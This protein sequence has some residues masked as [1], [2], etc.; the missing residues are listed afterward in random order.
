MKKLIIIL[1]LFCCESVKAQLKHYISIN[2]VFYANFFNGQN[3]K[4]DHVFLFPP[5]SYK[6]EKQK[7]GLELCYSQ[8]DV[9]YKGSNTAVKND[10][11]YIYERNLALNVHYGILQHRR[12]AINP[13]AGV[14]FRFYDA[15]VFDGWSRQNQYHPQYPVFRN[16]KENLLGLQ[17]GVNINVPIYWGIYANSNLRYNATPWAKYSKH[18]FL[19]EVGVGYCLQRKR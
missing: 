16:E 9:F 15:S 17:V 2:Q 19:A 5:I 14:I 3:G 6:I 13:L 8:A 7:W 11:N 12:I 1:L 4:L 10:M 18:I